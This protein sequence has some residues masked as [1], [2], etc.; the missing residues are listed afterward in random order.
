VT[1]EI[2]AKLLKHALDPGAT[3]QETQSYGLKALQQL[4]GKTEELHEVMQL[5]Q[6][7]PKGR[8]AP[9]QTHQKQQPDLDTLKAMSFPWGKYRGRTLGDVVKSDLDYVIWCSNNLKKSGFIQALK[10]VLDHE[11]S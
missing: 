2:I 6:P 3:D 5:L 8:P 7:A 4:K 10:I 1:L 9:K 11:L